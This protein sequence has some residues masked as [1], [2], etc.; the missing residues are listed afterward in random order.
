MGYSQTPHCSAAA[1]CSWLKQPYHI[2]VFVLHYFQNTKVSTSVLK[3]YTVIQYV[4]TIPGF[5]S[6]PKCLMQNIIL[7]VLTHI[8]LHAHWKMCDISSTTLERRSRWRH[9][10]R[11]PNPQQQMKCSFNEVHFHVTCE[12]LDEHTGCSRCMR[13]VSRKWMTGLKCVKNCIQRD[14]LWF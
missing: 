11:W 7:T 5:P 10:D 4:W 1:K 6:S 8:P 13:C 9:S 12:I 3:S 14:V 2:S